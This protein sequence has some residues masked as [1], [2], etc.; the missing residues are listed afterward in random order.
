MCAV[1]P[2]H[3]TIEP[4]NQLSEI[5]ERERLRSLLVIYQM[6]SKSSQEKN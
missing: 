6:N 1:M 5:A 3:L 4:K 2:Y